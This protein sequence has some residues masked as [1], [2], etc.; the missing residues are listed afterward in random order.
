MARMVRLA[1][2]NIFEIAEVNTGR[3]NLR[4][5]ASRWN[6]RDVKLDLPQVQ[7]CAE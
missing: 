5:I 7:N 4:Q 3:V 2:F 1:E 6:L